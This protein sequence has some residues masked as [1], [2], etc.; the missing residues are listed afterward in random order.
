MC[1]ALLR[2]SKATSTRPSRW[3]L[4]A[5]VPIGFMLVAVNYALLVRAAGFRDFSIPSIFDRAHS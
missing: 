3:W 4:L 1:D 2:S 5:F